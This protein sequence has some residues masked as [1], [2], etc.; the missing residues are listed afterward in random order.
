MKLI[1]LGATGGT[2][3]EMIRRSL[4]DGHSVIVIRPRNS[5]NGFSILKAGQ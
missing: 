5:S 4:V 1:I 3:L 2:G